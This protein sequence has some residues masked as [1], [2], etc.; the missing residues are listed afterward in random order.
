MQVL[1]L[2]ES[3]YSMET[4]MTATFDF[5]ENSNTPSS[6]KGHPTLNNF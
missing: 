1:K 3:L 5:K 2:S 4:L 6:Q